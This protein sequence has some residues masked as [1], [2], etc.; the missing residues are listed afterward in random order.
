MQFSWGPR[1]RLADGSL[2]QFVGVAFRIKWAQCPDC[3][4]CRVPEMRLVNAFARGVARFLIFFYNFIQL[5]QGGIVTGE[6][7]RII[8]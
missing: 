2:E 6:S 7:E 5:P 4:L 1:P 8:K 3:P